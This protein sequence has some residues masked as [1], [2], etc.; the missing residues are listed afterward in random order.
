MELNTFKTIL[1]EILI[2][3]KFAKKAGNY[4]KVD[5]DVICMIYPQR[6]GFSNAYYINIGYMIKE[7]HPELKN[8]KF[9]ESDIRTRFF[10]CDLDKS[11]DCFDLDIL[12]EADVEKVR[13]CFKKNLDHYINGRISIQGLK[14]LLKAEPVLLYQTKPKAKHLL[15]NDN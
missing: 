3:Y 7:F 9:L 4:V 8:P 1:N 5:E 10:T 2:D 15:A 12:R 11:P 13:I 14:G 6:S